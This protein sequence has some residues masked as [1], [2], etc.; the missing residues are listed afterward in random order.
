[1]GPKK[2]PQAGNVIVRNARIIGMIEA[3]KIRTGEKSLAAVAE[4]IISDW[5]AVR[6][7]RLRQ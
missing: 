5:F 4:R 3:E 2:K 6:E 1:M 7:A